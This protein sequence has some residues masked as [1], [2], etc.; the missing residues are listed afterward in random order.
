MK[1]IIFGGLY[2]AIG[3]ISRFLPNYWD[4][5][6]DQR[7][8]YWFPIRVVDDKGT[9]KTYMIDT[10][11]FEIPYASK[12]FNKL[13]IFLKSLG[14][15]KDNSWLAIT[16][17]NYY[18]SARVEITKNSIDIFE[19]VANLED[20]Q[21]CND[22]ETRYYN[23]EDVLNG[24][25]LWNYQRNGRGCNLKRKD[26]KTRYDYKIQSLIND[27]LGEINE[28]NIYDYDIKKLLDI[29][30]EA[31]KI[32]AEYNK[33]KVEYILKLQKYINRIKKNYLRYKS[34][35]KEEIL[36]LCKGSDER[37]VSMKLKDYQQVNM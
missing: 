29:E 1:E 30:K 21:M 5:L 20:Y 31:I 24:V 25:M 23:K 14:E 10:Y 12:E 36:E 18:Y 35:I 4:R 34:K 26:A 22:A 27:I 3:Q 19:L 37:W 13:V 7:Y 16:P 8:N 15:E 17:Y 32:G 28:P 2:R 6:N 9:D 33:S 11:Q